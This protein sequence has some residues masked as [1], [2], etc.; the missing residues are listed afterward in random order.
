[1]PSDDAWCRML[2]CRRLVVVLAIGS[3]SKGNNGR[4][5]VNAAARLKQVR[6]SWDKLGVRRRRELWRVKFGP[7]DRRQMAS[8]ERPMNQCE[9]RIGQVLEGDQHVLLMRPGRGDKQH[10]VP[11]AGLQSQ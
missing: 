5:T 11:L 7:V 9:A 3:E 1:M 4:Q 8:N 10:A 6:Q 2:N